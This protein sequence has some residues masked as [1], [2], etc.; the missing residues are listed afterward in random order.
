MFAIAME[1][2]R[3][4]F[5]K[6]QFMQGYNEIVNYDTAI[7]FREHQLDPMGICFAILMDGKETDETVLKEKLKTLADNDLKW[8]VV[9][10]EVLNFMQ[11]AP[12]KFHPYLVAWQMMTTGVEL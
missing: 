2:V 11:Q 3:H 4:Y 8:E 10:E 1:K 12:E 5:D 9:K 7:K 6:G